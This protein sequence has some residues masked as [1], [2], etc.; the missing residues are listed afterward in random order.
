M[1]F[2]E[3]LPTKSLPTKPVLK[4][5]VTE[6]LKIKAFLSEDPKRTYRHASQHF[7]VTKA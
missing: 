1:V 2:G 5:I 7:K 6:A 4:N 3:P